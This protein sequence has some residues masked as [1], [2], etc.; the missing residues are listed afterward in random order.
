[1][2][3]VEE[4]IGMLSDDSLLGS[5]HSPHSRPRK[6]RQAQQQQQQEKEDEKDS[7][8]EQPPFM[9]KRLPWQDE[10]PPKGA[11]TSGGEKRSGRLDYTLRPPV[12][13]G[14]QLQARELGFGAMDGDIANLLDLLG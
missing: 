14:K 13:G 10:P 11:A 2:D 9:L 6:H 7:E 12:G 5:E 1:M 4:V 8:A 3:E